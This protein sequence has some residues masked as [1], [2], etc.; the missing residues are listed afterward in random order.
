M[1]FWMCVIFGL[2]VMGSGDPSALLLGPAIIIGGV[3]LS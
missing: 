3:L 1:G 2:K